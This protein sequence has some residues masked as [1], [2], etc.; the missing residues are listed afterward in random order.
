MITQFADVW[1]L[2]WWVWG[3]LGLAALL[4]GFAKTSI[5]NMSL[6][7]VVAMAQILP[8]RDSTGVVLLLFLVGDLVAIWVYIKSVDWKL[9]VSLIVPVLVGLGLGAAFLNWVDDTVLKK[10]MGVIILVLIVLG[11]WPDK[12][13][14]QRKPVAFGYGAMAGFTTMVANAGGPA[15]SLY[16][17]AAKFDKLRFLGTSA[18]F[19]FFVN[20]S[21]APVSIG[22]GILR[23]EI[24]LFALALAP[25]TLVGTWLGRVL[26]KRIAQRTFEVLVTVFCA[27]SALYLI[28][29]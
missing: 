16:L 3:I 24:A 15:M 2:P 23:P 29:A 21:K 1:T 4:I 25:I 17:L 28:V 22:L 18:W 11:F 20:V 7:A 14:V 19:F 8:V 12:L 26:I 9:I 5:G 10:T 6:V 13:G 27:I